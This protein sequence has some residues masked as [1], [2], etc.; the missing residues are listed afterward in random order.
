MQVLLYHGRKMVVVFSIP[1][2]HHLRLA[3]HCK[4]DHACINLSTYGG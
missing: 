1:G 4:L 2:R 3:D